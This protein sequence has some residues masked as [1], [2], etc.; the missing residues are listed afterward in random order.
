MIGRAGSHRAERQPRTVAFLRALA[1]GSSTRKIWLLTYLMA[2]GGVF[3]HLQL[4]PGTALEGAPISIPWWV[5]AVGFAASS[6][7]VVHLPIRRDSHSLSISEVLLVVA[8]GFASP[9]ALVVGRLI[10]S[11]LALRFHRRQGLTKLAF[12][13]SLAYLETVAAIA[14]YRWFLHGAFPVGPRG[15][16]A[17]MGAVSVSVV[18]SVTL[19]TLVIAIHDRRRTI[20]EMLPSLV[21]GSIVSIGSGVIGLVYLILIWS[22]PA[23]VGL[24]VVLTPLIYASVAAFS[25]LAKQYTDLQSVFAFARE[26]QRPLRLEEVVSTTL[27]QVRQALRS[28]GAELIIIPSSPDAPAER[29][30]LDQ[31]GLH[32]LPVPRRQVTELTRHVLANPDGRSFSASRGSEALREQYEA[33]GFSTA[34]VALVND[35]HGVRAILAA[36]NRLGPVAAFDAADE[37]LLQVLAKQAGDTMVRSQLV[38]RLEEETAERERQAAQLVRSK[39]DFLASVS[40]ELRTPLTAVHGGSEVLREHLAELSQVEIQELVES[41]ASESRELAHIIDDLLVAARADLG[42]LTVKPERTLLS[43]EIHQVVASLE[44]A[45]G[46]TS[47]TVDAP[48]VEA[49]V[50]PLRFRQILRN[51]L[52]NAYRY[53]GEHV[54]VD[55][56]R[57]AGQWVVRVRDDGDGIPREARHDIFDPYR[58]AHER[59]G[60]TGSVGL[61]LS[62]ARQLAELLGGTL[63]YRYQDG[64][65]VFEL[66]IPS[67]RP[68]AA[69]PRSARSASAERHGA[70]AG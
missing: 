22:D 30:R 20:A 4:V 48:D 15:W 67:D 34:V 69:R 21:M 46:S 33:S 10:G 3:I 42:N 25:R 63:R 52:S 9:A 49:T 35:E 62:V 66:A 36:G 39:D 58:K 17:V 31:G 44:P 16:W 41:I 59:K 12:N 68:R 2:L 45:R 1:Q 43:A 6:V 26:I 64:H 56:R 37:A 18:V 54:V 61:G 23:T 60:V 38:E 70:L 32:R 47:L 8:L 65:S 24:V 27:E 55:V 19:V 51:L 5:L 28:E 13:V 29:T 14:A 57:G 40:H 53:G 11:G 50:D 7:F